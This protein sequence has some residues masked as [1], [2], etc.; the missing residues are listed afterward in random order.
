[1]MRVSASGVGGA[2]FLSMSAIEWPVL[3]RPP[4]TAAGTT[5][6]F[7]QAILSCFSVC[8]SCPPK[9]T[10]VLQEA[11]TVVYR[12]GGVDFGRGEF[13]GEN[14]VAKKRGDNSPQ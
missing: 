3:C 6:S 1:M 12:R 9:H 7:M 10:R 11:K 13:P 5:Q 4:C 8:L 14:F 2:G